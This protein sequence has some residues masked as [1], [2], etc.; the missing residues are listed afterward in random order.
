MIPERPK[1]DKK[2][3]RPLPERLVNKIA[4][5]EVIERPAAVL[6]ELVENSLDAGAEKIDIIVEKSGT[7]LISVI[8]DGCGIE[9]DQIEV[10]FARHATSKI[11]DFVD[12]DN[13]L[14]F[15]FRGEALPS[16]ASVSKTHLTS[17]TRASGSG[18][19]IIIEGGVVQSVKPVAAPDG[20]KVEV[21]DLFFNTPARRKF[22][23]TE[24][25]EARHLNRNAIALALGVPDVRFTYRINGRL[26]YT[27]ER[28]PGDFKSRV[29]R[30]LL[31]AKD[32][33][34]F[35]VTHDSSILKVRAY[36]GYP[37]NS[38][39]NQ[40]GLFIFVNR[41]YI[42]SPTIAHAV[43]LGYGEL[44]P[45]GNYPVGAVFLEIDPHQVDVNVHPTKAEV[46]LSGENQLHDLL[47]Q[48]IKRTI[49]QSPHD[50]SLAVPG[51]TAP[52][53]KS[54][55]VAEAIARARSVPP[56]KGGSVSQE[57]M[58]ELYGRPENGPRPGSPTETGDRR[59]L[60]PE[61]SGAEPS[62]LKLAE[63]SFIGYFAD[64]Y[65]LFKN[66]SDL[67]IIDQH[68]AHERILY[69]ENLRLLEKG[70][71][72]SQ[73]LLFPINIELSPERFSLFEESLATLESSGFV[74]QEFGA[75][76]ILLSA[77]PTSL[78]KKSPEKVF[79]E[80]LAD[81]EDL[82]RAGFD[83]QKAVAQSMAC[84]AA[85]M[86]G[87]ILDEKE[88]L[89]LVE[90]LLACENRHCCPHGRPTLLKISKN[91]LDGKFGR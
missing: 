49:R 30:L 51:Q 62:D 66:R 31:Q 58:R 77:V 28:T 26:L 9:P 29:A 73:N 44:L 53:P 59:P 41:R 52:S 83:L 11:R 56:E 65:L 24:M 20:T 86:A 13:L 45:R 6:K 85:I 84:R 57:T 5:G 38:R 70:G 8:D 23:K 46:R 60:S 27:A 32:K 72:V 89:G 75:S 43:I 50:A 19:E 3:I 82:R 33:G 7:R 63:M 15:G 1:S 61:P 48:A 14:S 81:I 55:T 21:F 36:L 22:L 90:R 35:E 34:L 40:H 25:T 79:H 69:E 37:E 2:W 10:A 4:A 87:D 88:A 42:K 54:M 80:I 76:T 47:Y 17:K 39:H 71:A 91:E 12:L 64:L 68:A 74:I 67:I 16:I 18:R 78:S